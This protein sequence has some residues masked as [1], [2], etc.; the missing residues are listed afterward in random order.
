MFVWEQ[1]VFMPAEVDAMA[2]S[3]ALDG[4]LLHFAAEMPDRLAT[5]IGHQLDSGDVL[6]AALA[7][8]SF[9]ARRDLLVSNGDRR[10]LREAIESHRGDTTSV[11]QLDRRA[12]AR[13]TP[14]V[15]DT[16]VMP[17]VPPQV[18]P[19][20]GTR[21]PVRREHAGGRPTVPVPVR[22]PERRVDPTAQTVLMP[23]IRG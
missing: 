16:R 19:R 23:A 22:R 11:D 14:P 8:A 5:A 6:G 7:L 15:A 18:P 1:G 21:Q 9:A 2:G 3:E 12:G 4:V 20:S 10:T 17:A 13:Q